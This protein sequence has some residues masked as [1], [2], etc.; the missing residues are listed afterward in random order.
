MKVVVK[1]PGSAESNALVD[2]LK[3]PFNAHDVYQAADNTVE[4]TINHDRDAAIDLLIGL[5][6]AQPW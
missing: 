4:I 5:V 1:T 3:N 2:A 6:T